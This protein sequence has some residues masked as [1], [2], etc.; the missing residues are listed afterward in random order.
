MNLNTKLVEL[1]DIVR[2]SSSPKHS[3]E[4]KKGG[5]DAPDPGPEQNLKKA[6]VFTKATDY[7][8][9]LEREMLQQRNENEALKKRMALFRSL[10]ALE[11]PGQ[12]REDRN[13][14]DI[15]QVTI[16]PK[17]HKRAGVLG[18]APSFR[19]CKPKWL[20]G[21]KRQFYEQGLDGISGR[22]DSF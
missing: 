10:T 12:R 15:L 13:A 14:Y 11:L 19:Q 16:S 17:P 5:A 21:A 2:S 18:R 3:E 9:Q 4:D 1:R 20:R 22:D 8:Y 6:Q 7:I